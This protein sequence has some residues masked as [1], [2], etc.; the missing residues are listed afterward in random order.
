MKAGPEYQA[1]MFLLIIPIGRKTGR[2]LVVEL[3][4]EPEGRAS[5]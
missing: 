5:N 4:I 1:R 2:P 3:N